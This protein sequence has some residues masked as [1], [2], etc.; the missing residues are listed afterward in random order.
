MDEPDGGNGQEHQSTRWHLAD[1]LYKSIIRALSSVVNAPSGKERWWERQGRWCLGPITT[2]S[3]DDQ[4][5]VQLDW[6]QVH[7]SVQSLYPRVGAMLW[8]TSQHCPVSNSL[9]FFFP[10]G[11]NS[12]RL[13]WLNWLINHLWQGRILFKHL[14]LLVINW[15]TAIFYFWKT[16]LIVFLIRLYRRYLFLINFYIIWHRK[17]SWE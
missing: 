7:A 9:S 17:T 15:A 14:N 6:S 10:L 12:Y 1:E 3:G 5:I 13:I 11:T 2:P 4:Y 16:F 8:N